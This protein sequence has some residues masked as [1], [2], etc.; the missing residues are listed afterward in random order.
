[1]QII[2]LKDVSGVGQKGSVKN[3]A[4]G[5]ALNSLIPRKLAQLATPEALKTLESRNAQEKK[6]RDDQEAQWAAIVGKMKN[7]T[8]ML[9]ANASPQGHLYKKITAEDIARVLGEQGINVPA[10]A[11]EPKMPI[12]QSGT[13]PVDIELG[14]NKA[15]I[16]VDV[17]TA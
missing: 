3:V 13:W 16:T 15:T 8:L 7:F 1:M 6:E 2:L 12:K 11:I 17:I 10:D 9:R 5:F 4:D 14:K